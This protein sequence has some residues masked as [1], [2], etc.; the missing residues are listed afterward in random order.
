[1]M[2]SST[3]T[4]PAVASS[5][6][7]LIE[8]KTLTASR[9]NPAGPET[10]TVRPSDLRGATRLSTCPTEDLSSVSSPRGFRL[11]ISSAVV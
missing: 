1:M 6:V 4:S 10:L 3:N 9:E 11:T 5:K 2:I 7:P 8:A